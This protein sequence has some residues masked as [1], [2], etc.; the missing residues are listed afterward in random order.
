MEQIYPVMQRLNQT[1]WR[2]SVEMRYFA[3]LEAV[4]RGGVQEN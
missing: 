2:H 3:V 4:R 1:D